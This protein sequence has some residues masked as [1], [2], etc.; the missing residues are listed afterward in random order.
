MLVE[1][2]AELLNKEIFFKVK[3]DRCLGLPND[4]C[5]NVFV[6]YIFKHEPD[7]IYRVPEFEGKNPNPIFDY[8]HVHRVDHVSEYFLDYITSGHIV[9]KTYGN[10]AFGGPIT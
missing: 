3:V 8:N 5:K 6:T 9:F 4:L 2:P 10:P 7:V 1:D